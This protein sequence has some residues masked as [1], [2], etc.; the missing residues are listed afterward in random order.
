MLMSG[1]DVTGEHV[2]LEVVSKTLVVKR[3]EGGHRSRS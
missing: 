3:K 2:S 1:C